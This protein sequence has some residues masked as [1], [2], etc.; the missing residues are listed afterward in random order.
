MNAVRLA[1]LVSVYPAVSHTFILRE[2]MRLR[3][4]GL[5]IVTASVNPPDRAREVMDDCERGEADRT[6]CLKTDG[7]RGALR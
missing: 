7:M 5:E 1:Y 2:I 3:E 4:L 6:Y